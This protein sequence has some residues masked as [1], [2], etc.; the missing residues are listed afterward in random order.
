[1]ISDRIPQTYL[2][3]KKYKT[4]FSSKK[5]CETN[6]ALLPGNEEI[7]YANGTKKEEL[8]KVDKHRR[9]NGI[10]I[11]LDRFA[12]IRQADI[13]SIVAPTSLLYKKEAPLK[14]TLYTEG[15]VLIV[16][17]E[18]QRKRAWIETSGYR[19]VKSTYKQLQ[20]NAKL[21]L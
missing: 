5:C 1:M 9:G 17:E 15:T 10:I 18:K 13:T 2:L 19:Q 21:Q 8:A 12:A 20:C 6:R 4:S 11:P 3:D 16:H 14:S 7:R